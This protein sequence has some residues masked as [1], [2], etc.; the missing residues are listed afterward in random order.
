MMNLFIQGIPLTRSS[1]D[2]VVS[3]QCSN[4]TNDK[5]VFFSQTRL[6]CDL[7]LSLSKSSV[8]VIKEGKLMGENKKSLLKCFHW[9]KV[10]TKS[11]YVQ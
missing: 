1:N 9:Q 10:F 7:N 2:F 6:F 8:S 3:F 11:S 5:H 4:V